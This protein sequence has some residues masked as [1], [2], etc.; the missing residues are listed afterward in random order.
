MAALVRFPVVGANVIEGTVGRWHR[1]EGERVGPGEPLVE[2]ITSK[3]TFDVESPDDGVLRKICAPEN[4]ILPV[5]YILAIVGEDG[6]DLP[7]T[8]CENATLVEEFRAKALD[9]EREQSAESVGKKIRATPGARR[10]AR[11]LNVDLATIPP[12]TDGVLRENDV[13][14]AIEDE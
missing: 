3:A 9:A 11:E 7:D 13:R 5:G 4:S 14:Q 1:R 12:P 8:T 10:L 6:E 2:I